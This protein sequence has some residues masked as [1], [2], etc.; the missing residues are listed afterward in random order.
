MRYNA[1]QRLHVTERVKE[2]WK[3]SRQMLQALLPKNI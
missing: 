1:S 3:Q 2:H